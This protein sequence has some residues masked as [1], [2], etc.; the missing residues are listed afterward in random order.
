MLVILATRRRSWKKRDPAVG[1]VGPPIFSEDRKQWG[2]GR[3]STGPGGG[4]G[5]CST[6]PR[7]GLVEVLRTPVEDIAGRAHWYPNQAVGP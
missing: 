2:P 5:R 3:D 6:D 4:L 1:P 7:G